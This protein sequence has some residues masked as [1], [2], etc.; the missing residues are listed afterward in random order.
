MIDC[1]LREK[2]K[3]KMLSIIASYL[4]VVSDKLKDK[5]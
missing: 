4:V 2:F 3:L 1:Y 5:K